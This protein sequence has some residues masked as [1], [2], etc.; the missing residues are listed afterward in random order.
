[1]VDQTVT[2]RP[3]AVA[4][5]AAGPRR[6]GRV[7]LLVLLAVTI[8]AV[9]VVVL[10]WSAREELAAAEALLPEAQAAV[11][12]ADADAATPL[13]READQHLRSA[14]RSLGNPLVA[15]AR[16]LPV[17]GRD[18]R[19]VAAVAGG[20]AQLTMAALEVVET[21]EELPDGLAS[22]APEGGTFP[23]ERIAALAPGLRELETAAHDAAAR[24]S[25]TEP[26]GLVGQVADAHGRMAELLT[27]LPEQATTAAG[28][29]EHLPAFLGAEGPRTY[30]IGASTPGAL[31]GTGGF[32]GA[33]AT[34]R[35][36]DGHL[37]IGSF[38]A[39]N[40]LRVL[41][42]D[43]LPPPVEED[44]ERWSRYGGTG[45]WLTLNRS[46][47]FPASAEAMTR[48]WEATVGDAADG[49]IVVDP[50]ALEALLELSGGEAAVP[51]TDVA[52]EADSVV[53]YV[54]NE[55]YGDFD[56]HDERKEVLGDVASAVLQRFL[57][58]DVG[59]APEEAITS[60]GGLARAGHL[61]IYS[62]E[63]EVQE[64]FS[65]AGLTGEIPETSGDLVQVVGNSGT[66]SKVDYYGRRWL[67]HDVTLLDDGATHNEL[68]VRIANEAPTD[69]Q[70][71]HVIG[72]NNPRLDAGE[73]LLDVSV[74]LAPDSR[75]VDVPAAEP[76]LPAFEETEVGHP[77]HDGWVLLA[78]G[79]EVER[80]Y[81]WRTDEAW[82]VTD[83]G[84]LTY[85]IVVQGQTTIE[86][87]EVVVRIN[88]P[89][90]LEVTRAPEELEVE[91]GVAVWRGEIRGERI[92]LPLELRPTS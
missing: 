58:G 48:H 53:S 24:L 86:P 15:P 42:G 82:R 18:L 92:T 22:L 56:S 66:A 13:L 25:D 71:G 84:A 85:E 28:L 70:P 62:V 23:V 19:A 14:D 39:T 10:L 21:L 49:L 59:L 16:L 67:E 4:D 6:R 78:S 64:A 3:D 36:H 55:A 89:G 65:R 8:W 2:R 63:T 41:P 77:V 5:D 7:L 27:P 87:T 30:V 43:E 17:L 44:A 50:F 46:P 80:R 26:S 20:G 12:D 83:E 52:L 88:I 33:A 57:V 76:D 38:R 9:V 72:P 69:G 81:V 90:G 45:D 54:A 73:N 51:G 68:L 29:A 61:R 32:I 40:D 11:A 34:A 75:F 31:G 91:D 79:E 37:D 47:H 1:M 74:V 35:M 60:L